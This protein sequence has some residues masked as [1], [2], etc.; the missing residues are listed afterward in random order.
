[1]Q[2][3]YGR[4]PDGKPVDMASL[5]RLSAL[6]YERCLAA[7]ALR[8]VWNKLLQRSCSWSIPSVLLG[9]SKNEAIFQEKL[10]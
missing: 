8:Q 2:A 7:E 3:K 4:T 6:G 5:D 9:E 10:S 1:M